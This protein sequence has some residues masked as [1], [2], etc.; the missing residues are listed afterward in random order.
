[1]NMIVTTLYNP[2][3]GQLCAHNIVQERSDTNQCT[4][5][6]HVCEHCSG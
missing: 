1:M 5:A 2:L 3:H 4:E 6:Y